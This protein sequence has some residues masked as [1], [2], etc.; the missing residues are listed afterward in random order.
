ML[1]LTDKQ[2]QRIS[3]ALAEPRRFRILQDLAADRTQQ[4]PCTAIV[5]CHGVSQATI[6]HHLK[7]LETAGLVEIVRDGKFAHV[8]FQR[9]VWR[10]YLARLASL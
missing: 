9:D 2:V 3:S 7:E 4:M 10:A 8:V 1:R 5:E 6:S